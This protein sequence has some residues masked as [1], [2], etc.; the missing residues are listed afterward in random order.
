[1][2]TIICTIVMHARLYPQADAAVVSSLAS[3]E[4]AFQPVLTSSHPQTSA[5]VCELAAV[6]VCVYVCMCVGWVWSRI[7]H[8]VL[9][10]ACS[11]VVYTL[12]P[13]YLVRTAHNC[14]F[15]SCIITSPPLDLRH[16]FYSFPL[17]Y[18]RIP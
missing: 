10:A 2:Q 13:F 7:R 3:Q 5:C 6:C 11:Y 8:F 18:S 17:H 16:H 12:T 15:M 4:H 9:K 14:H 1:M